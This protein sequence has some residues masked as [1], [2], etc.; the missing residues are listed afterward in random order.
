MR[1]RAR[2]HNQAESDIE[3][4]SRTMIIIRTV[5]DA[6]DL[7]DLVD[8]SFNRGRMNELT[9]ARTHD[10]HTRGSAR[11]RTQKYSAL[12]FALSPNWA[13]INLLICWRASK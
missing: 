3:R 4:P 6:D 8:R 5:C 11:P 2:F 12:L 13:R 9:G 1:E 7:F 10:V